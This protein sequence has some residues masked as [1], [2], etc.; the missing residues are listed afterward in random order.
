MIGICGASGKVGYTLYNLMDCLGTYCNHPKP[1]LLH[2]NMLTDSFDIFKDCDCVIIT[3]NHADVNYCELH[4]EETELLNVTKT[5]E[6]IKYLSDN[7]IKSVFLSSILAGTDC[8]YG[9]QKAT[10]EEYIVTN[11]S[12]S[13]IR[14]PEFK[15]HNRQQVC[16][17]ILK[18]CE[19][20]HIAIHSISFFGFDEPHVWAD[21]PADVFRYTEKTFPLRNRLTPHAQSKIPKCFAW[22]MDPG[23]DFYI[24]VDA[25]YQLL[26]GAVDF[27][28][29]ELGDND[30][31]VF[32]HPFNNTVEDE[33]NFL[34]Q[35]LVKSK[36]IQLR[37]KDEL[38][39]EVYKLVDGKD[40]VYHGAIY[41]Y[42]NTPE[43]QKALKEWWYYDSRFHLDD[44]LTW[45]H[46]LKGLKVKVMDKGVADYPYWRYIPHHG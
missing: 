17:D 30:F 7:N 44:Q 4:P 24:W 25:S 38:L 6:L 9:R 28:L 14:L 31:L 23:Y 45:T 1:G 36:Y 34:K 26:D 41:I 2:F 40:P 22:D 19:T 15:K 5:I 18:L 37:Y 12:S 20:R 10:V 29:K 13:Y 39:E 43:V 42:R 46:V 3:S 35:G 33:Y 11:P 32:P 8:V 21:Q 16:E 27:L